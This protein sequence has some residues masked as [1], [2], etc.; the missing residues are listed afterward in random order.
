[1]SWNS[2]HDVNPLGSIPIS[3][4]ENLAI[5]FE[6]IEH[7]RKKTPASS[8]EKMKNSI[9]HRLDFN[10]KELIEKNF[11][12]CESDSF[13][14]KNLLEIFQKKQQAEKENLEKIKLD[15]KRLVPLQKLNQKRRNINDPLRKSQDFAATFH[16]NV[17]Q[18]SVLRQKPKEISHKPFITHRV[19]NR[20]EEESS[21]ENKALKE[22]IDLVKFHLNKLSLKVRELRKEQIEFI[23]AELAKRKSKLPRDF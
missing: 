17:R 23:K 22:G 21:E 8:L 19:H 18:T 2:P 11:G 15:S 6:N 16:S 14:I 10:K 7:A 12:I 1:M 4:L 9:I 5:S 3:P 13:L 20:R